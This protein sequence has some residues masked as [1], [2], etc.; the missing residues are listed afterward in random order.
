MGR[1]GYTKVFFAGHPGSI[2]HPAAPDARADGNGGMLAK[3]W[4]YRPIYPGGI[5]GPFT[6]ERKARIAAGLD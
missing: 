4:Y 1:A 5:F 3:G 6:T 2:R